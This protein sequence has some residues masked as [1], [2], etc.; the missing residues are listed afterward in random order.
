MKTLYR[1]LRLISLLAQAGYWIDRFWQ[2]LQSHG[3]YPMQ[4][5]LD[6]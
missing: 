3:V 2:Q 6:L 4:L 5:D 1:K